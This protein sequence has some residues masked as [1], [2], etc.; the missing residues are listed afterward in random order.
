MG[1]SGDGCFPGHGKQGKTGVIAER[2]KLFR[3]VFRLDIFADIQDQTTAVFIKQSF[4]QMI[5]PVGILLTEDPGGDDE[6]AAIQIAGTGQRFSNVDPADRT[7]KT[8][9]TGEQLQ[10]ICGMGFV[11]QVL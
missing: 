1:H 6:L 7:F 3:D 10:A 4:D 5:Q 2:K 8:G 11:I 9:A